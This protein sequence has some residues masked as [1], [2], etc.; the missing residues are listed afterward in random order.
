ML[1]RSAWV[2]TSNVGAQPWPTALQHAKRR[3]DAKSPNTRL[4][5]LAARL[6]TPRRKVAP[7]ASLHRL[8]GKVTPFV[9]P[10]GP[11]KQLNP[12]RRSTCPEPNL[13][14]AS[15]QAQSAWATTSDVG[16][17]PWPPARLTAKRRPDAKLPNGPRVLA[18]A[19]P[20]NM[21]PKRTVLAASRRRLLG[22]VTSFASEE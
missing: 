20:P 1:A 17:Q 8:L 3:P 16:V 2:T 11:K 21:R 4:V 12:N 13:F 22:K 15:W 6:S 19:A 18:L 14:A 10:R 7:A 5:K 9:V